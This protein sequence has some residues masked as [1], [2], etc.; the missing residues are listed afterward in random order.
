M[1]E[2]NKSVCANTLLEDCTID[3]TTPS[4]ITNYVCLGNSATQ[5]FQVLVP[6]LA[7]QSVH[8]VLNLSKVRLLIK[9][10][11]FFANEK[12]KRECILK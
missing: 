10:H 9:Y 7:T 3:P 12:F 4:E 6:S 5:P 2:K 8:S 1:C 11:A